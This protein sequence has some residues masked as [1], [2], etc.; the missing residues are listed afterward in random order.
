MLSPF[1]PVSTKS[2][3]ISQPYSNTKY[4]TLHA[5]RPDSPDR[6]NYSYRR[7]SLPQIH[8][9]S[10][11]D[12]I[13]VTPT[14]STYSTTNQNR[15]SNPEA[16]S[17]YHDDKYMSPGNVATNDSLS[18]SDYNVCGLKRDVNIGTHSRE[19]TNE[20]SKAEF[21]N[22]EAISG[23]HDDKY[24]S[25][26]NVA[27][28]DLLSQSDHN[29]SRLK[30]DVNIGT[31]SREKTNESSKAEFIENPTDFKTE[32]SKSSVSISSQ[33]LQNLDTYDKKMTVNNEQHNPIV[34]VNISL[35]DPEVVATTAKL[36]QTLFPI[37]D[38]NT[39]KVPD[40]TLLTPQSPL[41]SNKK[42]SDVTASTSSEGKSSSGNNIQEDKVT[43]VKKDLLK[44]PQQKTKMPVHVEKEHVKVSKKIES[45]SSEQQVNN[46][47]HLAPK[48]TKKETTL[49]KDRDVV[50][51]NKV[52]NNNN[53][54]TE[55]IIKAG[56]RE[57][58]N[59]R[60]EQPE[61]QESKK[62]EKRNKDYDDNGTTYLSIC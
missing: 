12:S 55:E 20:S 35:S 18:Q 41:Q 11:D 13:C 44:P 53:G 59:E 5:I 39:S 14:I 25:P 58:V 57:V 28:D 30:T 8:L 1:P 7:T 42:S 46:K 3:E 21:S 47:K 60:S 31:H 17:G 19:K 56:S 45:K 51:K 10:T 61:A 33:S 6:T 15:Y 37:E 34:Q 49:R 48:T 50:N 32:L 26:G 52:A 2:H 23:Y 24:M 54:T 27:T 43:P 4:S 29:V 22:P 62:I 38:K 36:E 16:I 9:T 40:K